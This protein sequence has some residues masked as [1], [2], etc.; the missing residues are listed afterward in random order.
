MEEHGI[1]HKSDLT[2]RKIQYTFF[3]YSFIFILER[4]VCAETAA[5]LLL[6]IIAQT[7]DN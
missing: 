5:L 6:A 3:I 4:S 1:L 2:K 7:E